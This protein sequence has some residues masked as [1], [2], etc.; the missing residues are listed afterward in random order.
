MTV[1]KI[2]HFISGLALG[3]SLV[4]VGFFIATRV[5]SQNF[6][7]LY[8]VSSGSMEPHIKTGSIVYVEPQSTYKLNDVV[9][10]YPN[11]ANR[12]ATVTHRIVAIGNGVIKTAGDAN[13]QAETSLTPVS[14]IVGK[15]IIS[16]PFV[17][18][19][20]GFTKTPQGF[21]LMVIIPATIIIYEELK[22]ISKTLTK[23]IKPK[24]I[25]LN[26]LY[27]LAIILPLV[28]S[29]LVYTSFS[30]SYFSDL[31]TSTTNLFTVTSSAP[32]PAN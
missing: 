32:T 11:V 1:T 23:N 3:I 25:T 14:R 22:N 31:V 6:G 4:L 24:K 5:E 30:N 7:R 17:G 15:V 9:T 28:G 2:F 26:P 13:N 10:F 18:Y 21:I 27:I 20:A 12:R 29:A 16:V 19:L 8:V